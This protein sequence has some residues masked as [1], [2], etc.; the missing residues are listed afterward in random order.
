MASKLNARLEKLESRQCPFDRNSDLSIVLSPIV[1]DLE[2][3]ANDRKSPMNALAKSLLAA[4][5]GQGITLA[6]MTTPELKL[7]DELI[8]AFQS[9]RH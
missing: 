7:V 9:S 3:I 2:Q 8:A 1:V 5:Q 4:F 6:R